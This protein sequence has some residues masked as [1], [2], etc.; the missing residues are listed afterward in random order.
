M[1]QARAFSGLDTARYIIHVNYRPQYTYVYIIES[2]KLLWALIL[3]DI[4]FMW[5]QFSTG[6]PRKSNC[7]ICLSAY[8]LLA[9]IV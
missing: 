5:D 4:S 8:Y 6:Y 3:L 9:N 1:I 2:Y 7:E